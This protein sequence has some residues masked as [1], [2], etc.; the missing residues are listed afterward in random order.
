MV[1]IYNLDL[2]DIR[3]HGHVA[4]MLGYFGDSI[5]DLYPE[6]DAQLLIQSIKSGDLILL[7][8]TDDKKEIYG[9]SI[10]QTIKHK[11]NETSLLVL[12][13]GGHDM[14]K[15]IDDYFKHLETLAKDINAFQI[16]SYRNGR[17]WARILENRGY[18]TINVTI[19]KLK[20]KC[21]N[22]NHLI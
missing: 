9:Y 20:L 1:N 18:D 22:K 2:N 10:I 17:A 6:Y 3:A 21:A 8:I 15:W 12:A 13:L 14:K 16:V 19:N 11:T 4:K 7:A 5:N